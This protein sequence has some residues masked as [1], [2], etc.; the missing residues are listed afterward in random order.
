MT[1]CEVLL[2]LLLGFPLLVGGAPIPRISVPHQDGGV[3]LF[4]DEGIYNYTTFLL[5]EDLGVL[6]LGAC[7][8]IYALDINNISRKTAELPWSVPQDKRILCSHK[9]KKFETDCRNYIRVLQRADDD[10]MYVCGTNAFNPTCTYMTYSDGQLNFRDK[11]D[12]GKGKSPFDPYQRHASV[13]LDG[14]MYSATSSNFMGYDLALIVTPLPDAV[15]QTNAATTNP[16]FVHMDVVRESEGSTGDDDKV[17]MF[18]TENAVEFDYPDKLRLSRIAR[19]AKGDVG[20]HRMLS[21]RWTT[22]LKARLDCRSQEPG[23]PYIIQNV[24]LLEQS[25]WRD[26]IFYAVFNAQDSSDQSAVCAYSVSAIQDLFANGRYKMPIRGTSPVKWTTYY[27]EIPEPRPGAGINAAARAIGI[28]STLDLPDKTLQFVRDQPLMDEAVQPLG[29]GPRL[30]KKGP[31]FTSIAVNRVMAL[32][33]RT[34][35]VMFIG[36]ENGLMQKAVNY[37]GEMFV[38]EEVQLLPVQEP[39]KTLHLSRATGQLYAGSETAAAQFPVQQ[40]GRL[41][42]CQDCVRL[43]DPHCAWDFRSQQLG[44]L[45]TCSRYVCLNCR[46]PGEGQES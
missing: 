40:C 10:R 30:L 22:F 13:I 24:F 19:V 34:Y 37:D 27:G 23:L 35:D 21:K 45:T 26:G 32:D 42:N 1:V 17:Y 4:R 5:R 16:E 12:R 11:R 44:A 15:H 36:T 2:L 31:K 7:D 8:A 33:G 6:F 41:G 43:R 39:V 25:D 18:F 29:G 28:E 14:D 46:V 9:G 3:T 20:G 38:I